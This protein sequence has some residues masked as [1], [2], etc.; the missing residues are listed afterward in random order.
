M[1]GAIVYESHRRFGDS[2][3]ERSVSLIPDYLVSRHADCIVVP[4]HKPLDSIYPLMHS[5]WRG[6]Y[7]HDGL[8]RNYGCWFGLRIHE[9]TYG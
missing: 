9:Q 6:G 1:V 4:F 5:I 7:M 2:G 3:T 8:A